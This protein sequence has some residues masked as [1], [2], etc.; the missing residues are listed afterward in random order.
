[1]AGVAVR[2]HVPDGS[3]PVRLDIPPFLK[4]PDAEAPGSGSPFEDDRRPAASRKRPAREARQDGGHNAAD[5]GARVEIALTA[6][7]V[8]AGGVIAVLLV[9]QA[10]GHVVA[11]RN[12]RQA[13][14]LPVRIRDI[15]R[16]PVFPDAPD[17]KSGQ[18]RHLRFIPF[19]H[20]SHPFPDGV[21]LPGKTG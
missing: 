3:R 1:M 14:A 12:G 15:S 5:V 10:D 4:Q 13:A 18:F 8:R 9:I 11:E 6:D 21:L 19:R 16:P 20:G 2:H 17:Q 7:P